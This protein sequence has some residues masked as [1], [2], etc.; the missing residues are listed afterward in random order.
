MLGYARLRRAGLS[1]EMLFDDLHAGGVRT[2]RLENPGTALKMFQKKSG[3]R[4]RLFQ[5]FSGNERVIFQIN[6]GIQRAIFQKKS[7]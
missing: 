2:Q 4:V 1:S 5:K 3:N 6:F 7:R